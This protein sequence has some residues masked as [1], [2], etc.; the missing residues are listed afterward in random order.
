MTRRIS[1]RGS[2]L[3]GALKDRVPSDI[4]L[5]PTLT[6]TRWSSEAEESVSGS[7]SLGCGRP[8]YLR[9]HILQAEAN[10]RHSR[11]VTRMARSVKEGGYDCLDHAHV[12]PRHRR[13]EPA[14]CRADPDVQHPY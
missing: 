9:L 8:G 2:S 1:R 7:R 13:P 5:R 10:R 14:L 4:L 11:V 3:G 12:S 6:N